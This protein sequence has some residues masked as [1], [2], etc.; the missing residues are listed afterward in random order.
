MCIVYIENEMILKPFKI[1]LFILFCFLAAVSANAAEPT[2]RWVKKGVKELNK[3]R[4]NDSYK[5][6]VSQ[7]LYPN[8]KVVANDRFRSLLHYV[9]TTYG[10]SPM[11]MSLDS[12]VTENEPTTYVVSY[13]KRGKPMS[14]YAQLV[15]EYG[16]FEDYADNTFAYNHYQ[17]YALS[18]PNVVPRFDDFSLVKKYN[19]KAMMMSIVPGLGQI[20]KGQKVKGSLF[21]A[22]EIVLIS[23][24]IYSSAEVLHYKKL[25]DD[26]PWN[27]KSYK[28]NIR[29]FKALRTF[30]VVSAAGLYVYNI[31][32]AAFMTGVR[33][34]KVE[35]K[36]SADMEM[37]FTPLMSPDMAGVGMNIKF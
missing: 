13:Y 3:E 36:K 15:D 18:E 37:T 34:V 24:I 20:Y 4:S 29:T 26:D 25:Q 12:I 31:F 19:A 28:S 8:A 27:T 10:V 7:M 22:S 17:L 30:C 23:G 1:H 21:L 33:Y 6:Y 9:D 35:R 14:V 16:R 32:D 5:F 11:V 2:P